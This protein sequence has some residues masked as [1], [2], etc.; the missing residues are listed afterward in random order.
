MDESCSNQ[1]FTIC[2]TL[3]VNG[4]HKIG[5]RRYITIDFSKP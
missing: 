2:I 1:A 5:L 4:I 3:S